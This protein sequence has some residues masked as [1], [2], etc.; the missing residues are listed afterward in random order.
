MDTVSLVSTIL[1]IVFVLII[2]LT[3]APVLIWAER[4]QSAMIQDRIGPVR[5]GIKIGGKNITLLGLL[6]PMA[7]A[8]KFIWKEDFIPPKA[9]KLLHAF[10]PIVALVPAI[11]VFAVIPFGGYLSL[12]HAFDAVPVGE[13]VR[14]AYGSA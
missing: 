11:S 4:R 13:F 2:I 8:I 6:H 14:E 12:E 5:A 7:D 1:K 3:F 9:D 10:A